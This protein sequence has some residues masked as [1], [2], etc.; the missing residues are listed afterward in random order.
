MAW[1]G[2]AEDLAD[3]LACDDSAIVARE[4]KGLRDLILGGG[5]EIG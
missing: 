2:T 1:V 3:W 5:G 4:Q